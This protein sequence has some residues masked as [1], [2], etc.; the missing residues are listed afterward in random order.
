MITKKTLV[1]IC[2]ILAMIFHLIYYF[3]SN[4]P[5][6]NR[7]IFNLNSIL[8]LVS[9]LILIFVY[10]A[11]NWRVDLKGDFML[12]MYDLMILWI[13]ICF[14]RGI[15]DI[16][17]RIEWKESLFNPYLG[18]SLFPTLFFLVGINLKYFSPINKMLSVYC[19]LSWA[20]S[21]FYMVYPELQLFLLLP[22]F[23]VIVTYPLQSN[24]TRIL[25][26]II[27]VNIIVFSLTNRAGVMRLLI[28]YIIVL[29]YY[30][31]YKFK[32]NKKLINIVVFCLLLSPI[33]S[34]YLGI[35]GKNVF[36]MV[37]RDYTENY[38]QDNLT[39]DT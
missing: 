7:L 27:S 1:I 22:I 9:V 15:S 4:G 17:G 5:E 26:L 38:R 25:T 29:I 21:L 16:H 31:I 11:T 12:G 14:F 20:F 35:T 19:A 3:E 30:I 34:I 8:P 10:I 6:I 37:L 39:A 13:F 18:L 2:L 36:K 24:K 33:F 32:L 28:S 23:Y